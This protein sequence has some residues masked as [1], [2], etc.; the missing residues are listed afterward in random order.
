[1]QVSV[2]IAS[3]SSAAWRASGTLASRRFPAVG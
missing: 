3:H 1:L 2:E